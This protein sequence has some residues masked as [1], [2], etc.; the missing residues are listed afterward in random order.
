MPGGDAASGA[1]RFHRTALSVSSEAPA[2]SS[3]P[4][5]APWPPE[6]GTKYLTLSE[7]GRRH[8]TPLSPQD[9]HFISAIDPGERFMHSRD[10]EDRIEIGTEEGEPY[11]DVGSHLG[12][13]RGHGRATFKPM[14]PASFMDMSDEDTADGI[15]IILS[16]AM[17]HGDRRYRLPLS[18]STPSL[19][20]LSPEELAE[21]ERRRKRE[22]LAKLHRFLG[23]RVPTDLVLGPL[24]GI[25]LPAP[26]QSPLDMMR[27]EEENDLQRMWRRRRRSS[28]AAEFAGKWSEEID[29][30]KEELNGREKAINVRRAVKMEKV[31]THLCICRGGNGADR[32]ISCLAS[33]RRKRSS[34]LAVHRLHCRPTSPQPAPRTRR[35]GITLALKGRT[36]LLL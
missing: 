15:S 14:S 28:S 9:M 11:S 26:A 13:G 20:S 21:E 24:G 18:P 35:A 34:I 22:K 31:S 6:E 32:R 4:G 5:Q 7:V 25:P 16:P 17:K 12:H 27:E 30:L 23:S 2:V 33:R 1:R 3:A 36:H 10:P 29:R 19:L 8:S